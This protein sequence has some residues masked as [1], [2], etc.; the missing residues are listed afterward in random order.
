MVYLK[1]ASLLVMGLL[2]FAVAA[3]SGN[4]GGYSGTTGG[5]AA[6]QSAQQS[7]QYN[8]RMHDQSSGQKAS[9][10]T[11]KQSG[12]QV[13]S[14]QNSQKSNKGNATTVIHTAMVTL[15][16]KAMTIL[17]TAGGRTLYYRTS[18]PAPASTCTGACAKTWP[19]LIARGK[20]IVPASLKGHVSVHKTANGNQ[21]EFNG[22]PLYTYAGDMAARQAKGQGLGG[23]WFVAAIMQQQQ[24]QPR[25]TP[26]PPQPTGTPQPPHW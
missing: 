4:V 2:L 17:T 3:C 25:Q 1:R 6:Q 22:H 12:M 19:P 26:P 23:I 5:Q 16:G 13:A 10:A 11:N 21:V 20:L 8:T 18:D 14:Q 24:P 7:S 9:P 15:N